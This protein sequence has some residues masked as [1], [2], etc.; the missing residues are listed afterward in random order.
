MS[1]ANGPPDWL[2]REVDRRLPNGGGCWTPK[3]VAKTS[4]IGHFF[5]WKV[6][7]PTGRNAAPLI[8]HN[9]VG[10]VVT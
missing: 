9:W 10:S 2:F 4:E 3:S 7:R 8:S 1:V 5:V 6:F